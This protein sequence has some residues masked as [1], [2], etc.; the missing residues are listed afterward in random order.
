MVDLSIVIP[1]Y[2]KNEEL[3]QLTKNA[4]HSF[5]EADLPEYELILVDD[6]SPIGSSYLR[7]EA[8]TY[9]LHTKNQGFIKSVN[10]GLKLARGKY[11]AVAN[12]DIKVAPNFYRVAEEIFNQHYNIYSVHPRMLFYNDPIEYGDHT[13]LEGRERWCQTSFFLIRASDKHLF[14][15][16]YE[17]TGGAYEDWLY[18]TRTRESGRRTAYT[19]KTCFR[20]ADSSTTQV[21]GEQNKH[22]VENKE[23]FKKEFGDYPEEY[24]AKKYPDQVA[25][26]WRQEFTKL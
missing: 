14:P 16:E 23:L 8:D 11:I 19:T 2:L 13:Y 17:G 7:Q 12:N 3:L 4:I 15:E 22:H 9:V 24:F 1:C 10:D 6:G 21:V 20:H 5:R 26:N 18:H 25:L